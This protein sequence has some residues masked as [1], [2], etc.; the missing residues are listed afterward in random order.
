[1]IYICQNFDNQSTS[2]STHG[3][4]LRYFD[5]LYFRKH[6]HTLCIIHTKFE[7]MNIL[8]CMV[9]TTYHSYYY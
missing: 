3:R 4:E 2:G 5:F 1:M 7:F 6:D 8:I 9:N